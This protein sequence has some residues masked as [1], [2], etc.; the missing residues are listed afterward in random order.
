MPTGP[1][2]PTR[3]CVTCSTCSKLAISIS[4]APNNFNAFVSFNSR[5]P[6]IQNA[7]TFPSTLYS[8][9]LTKS[10]SFLPK[11]A[12]TSSIVFAF[13]VSTTSIVSSSSLES[14][15]V[16]TTSVISKLLE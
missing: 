3:A 2:K 9:V 10:L 12:A 4:L 1:A 13:G 7:I 16:S 15:I 14:C 8:N 11:K 6:G 5:S